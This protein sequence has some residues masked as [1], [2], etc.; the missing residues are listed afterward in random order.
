MAD[1]LSQ[2]P[3]GTTV[4]LFI[5]YGGG[6]GFL[7][8]R[9]LERWPQA[10]AIVFEPYL[11]FAEAARRRLAPWPG[12]TVVAR[13]RDLPTGA[14][15]VFCTEVFE[16]LPEAES[17]QA[18]REIDRVLKVGG[19]M[20]VGVPVEIGLPALV[21]GL[22]RRARRP[23]AYDGDLSRI[24]KAALGRPAAD[25]P[26]ERMGEMLRY[27]SFHL[28][29]DFRRLRARLEA[30]SGV[31]RLV[32]SPFAAAPVLLSSEA[33]MTLTKPEVPHMAHVARD[34]RPTDKAERYREVIDEIQAVLAGEHNRIARMATVASMLA[35]AFPAFIWTG[36]YLVDENRP[37]EL[38]VGPYQG[39]LGCLRI[40]FGRGVCGTAA[41]TRQT[42]VIE[43]VHAFAGHIACDS[44]SRSEIVVPVL[45]AD[46]QLIAV[47]D[48][49][50]ADHATF[51]AV[52]AQ[53]LE[54]LVQ[55][56]FQDL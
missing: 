35:D 51:D 50:S 32:G 30:R 42:Q 40:A 19:L 2:V 52:D 47:L 26:L 46:A 48:I 18:I 41:Q 38:V 1:A 21:K 11:E 10:R 27:H 9:A 36:F 44:R 24:W 25:R 43:D 6:D 5:D 37:D 49:D 23:D 20:I 39:K 55:A 31:A 3:A 17:D 8:A 22:F 45:G 54:R 28:G 14:D 29:F 33:Y 12:A 34:D 16:H 15:V 13:A 56:V 4:S 7:A 53:S